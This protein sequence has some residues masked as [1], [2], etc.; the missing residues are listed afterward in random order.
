MTGVPDGI[1]RPVN[2]LSQVTNT[3]LNS[4]TRRT[5]L[6][7]QLNKLTEAQELCEGLVNSNPDQALEYHRKA[8]SSKPGDADI[9]YNTGL[10]LQKP[11]DAKQAIESF[12]RNPLDN[13][14]SLFF[15]NFTPL[16]SILDSSASSI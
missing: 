8:G 12:R 14:M 9:H 16:I 4:E 5:I 1:Q 6:L 11:G 15:H 10:A 7:L 13:C 2:R 3:D